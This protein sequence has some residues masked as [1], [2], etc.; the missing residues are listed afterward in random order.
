MWVDA[1]K[2]YKFI[3]CNYSAVLKGLGITIHEPKSS[4]DDCFKVETDFYGFH[5]YMED[6]GYCNRD[7]F[8]TYDVEDVLA[9]IV[10]YAERLLVFFKQREFEEYEF[11]GIKWNDSFKQN[12]KDVVKWIGFT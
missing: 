3:Q 10:L 11:E 7:K 6:Q 5:Q 2:V 4:F 9:F 8:D 12:I 1:R